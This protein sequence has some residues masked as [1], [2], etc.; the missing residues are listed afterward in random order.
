MS[1]VRRDR[2]RG[3]APISHRSI[4]TDLHHV[5]ITVRRYQSQIRRTRSDH[6]GR[7]VKR[8]EPIKGTQMGDINVNTYV[9]DAEAVADAI[10]RRLLAGT[11]R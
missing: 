6:S 1:P 5:S 3:D 9:V 2:K 7:G 10:V 4:R 8:T 11:R